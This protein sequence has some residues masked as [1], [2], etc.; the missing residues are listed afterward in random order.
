MSNLLLN[1][2]IW[3][4]GA[5]S[6]P[7][8]WNGT[9]YECIPPSG[10]G[11]API[12]SLSLPSDGY[13]GFTL[14]VITPDTSDANSH[15]RVKINNTEVFNQSVATAGSFPFTSSA[16][17]AGDSVV[18]DFYTLTGG[19]EYLLYSGDYEIAPTADPIP[20][21]APDET[22]TT[23]QGSAVTVTPVITQSGAP[24]TPDSLT[25]L[26]QPANGTASVSGVALTY[27]PSAYYLGTDSFTYK[28]TKSGLDSAPA[29]VTVGIASTYN[30][31]CDDDFPTETM[32]DLKRRIQVRLGRAAM[33]IMPAGSDEMIGDFLESAQKLLFRKYTCF[34]TERWFTWD[35]PAGQRFFDF[36]ANRDECNKK[37]DPR[38]ITWVGVSLGDANWRELVSGINPVLYSPQQQ[39]VS[40][41]FEVRQCI[42]VWPAMSNDSWQLRVKGIF[43][44]MP[45]HDDDD[46]TSIDAEA[47]FML[48]LAN[49]KAHYGQGDAGNYMQELAEYIGEL[50]AG[51]QPTRRFFPGS[52]TL[53]N[54]VRPKLVP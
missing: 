43:G 45:F 46:V 25:I 6:P 15:C 33:T 49:A 40:Q 53:P 47:V 10:Q 11:V 54:A 21:I 16:L 8:S 22:L 18:I 9:A 28:A 42:E 32:G 20:P 23:T 12:Q 24:I 39:S 48:A 3:S 44:L 35:M 7:A 37:L 19:N 29:T 2:S 31:D 13:V 50:T 27:T 34:R 14:N 38:L 17:T 41:Y 26:T 52:R 51:N 4:D 5:H 36:G 30:C 1:A